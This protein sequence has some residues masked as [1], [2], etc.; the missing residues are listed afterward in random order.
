MKSFAITFLL[1]LSFSQTAM[2]S[3]K[4]QNR[5]RRDDL[6]ER[7]LILVEHANLLGDEEMHAGE[8]AKLMKNIDSIDDELKEL[9]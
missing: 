6:I 2:A 4:D 3:K 1:I 8:F 7:R 5:A 9:Q